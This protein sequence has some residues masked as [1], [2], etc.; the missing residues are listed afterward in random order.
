MTYLFL[1]ALLA[2]NSADAAHP[3][4]M[5]G[6]WGWQDAR[7]SEDDCGSDHTTTYHRNGTYDFI[8]QRG[9]WRIEGNR[10]IE[11]VTDPGE[12][13]SPSDRGTSNVF[14][15]KKVRAGVLQVS[16]EYPGQL[17]KCPGG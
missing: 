2:A 1:F 14:R 10:L 3:S 5:V 8:D 13:G 9:T 6:T 12:S 4:W 11:T 16:G 7:E 15:F 17:I